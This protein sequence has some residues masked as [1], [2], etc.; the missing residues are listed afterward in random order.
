MFCNWL[1]MS[2]VTLD[3]VIVEGGVMVLSDTTLKQCIS[4]EVVWVA[5]AAKNPWASM[6]K[7]A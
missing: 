6:S 5:A 7:A 3:D 4:S 1:A 2:T